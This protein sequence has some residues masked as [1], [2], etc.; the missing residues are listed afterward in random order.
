MRSDTMPSETVVILPAPM[1]IISA[2]TK[3]PWQILFGR[4]NVFATDKFHFK[5]CAAADILT[6]LRKKN[7]EQEFSDVGEPMEPSWAAT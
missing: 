6:F 5:G 2:N 1:R 7:V 3:L 4:Q